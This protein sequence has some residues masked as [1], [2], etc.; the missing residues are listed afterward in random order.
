MVT[1]YDWNEA[2]GH[3]AQFIE[4]RLADGV[5]VVAVSIDLGIVAGTFRRQ[6]SKIFEVY[7]RLMYAAV[8]QQSDVESLRVAAIDFAHREG[9]QRSEQ[10]VTIQRIVT[11]MSQPIKDAFANFSS[12]PWIGRAM[13]MEVGE[14]REFDRYYCI[15]YDGDYAT[16]KYRSCLAGTREQSDDIEAVLSG[17]KPTMKPKE[18]A[19]TLEKT[20]VKAMKSVQDGAQP[21]LE[22]LHFEAFLLARNKTGD[23]RFE[24]ITPESS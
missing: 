7:D 15:D 5:P 11:A 8:G 13:F 23:R 10:D 24:R 12:A 18:C 19:A 1:P 21:S 6:T 17:L 2:I 14:T 20:I 9:Y 16:E 22:D 3:R 4:S